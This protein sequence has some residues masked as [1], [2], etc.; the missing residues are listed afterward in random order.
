MC[1]W[2]YRPPVIIPVQRQSPR[3]PIKLDW[4]GFQSILNHDNVGVLNTPNIVGEWC[5]Y[6]SWF[7]RGLVCWS[8][9]NVFECDIQCELNVICF[10]QK[11]LLIF[12]KIWSWIFCEL[13]TICCARVWNNTAH[14]PGIN[15]LADLKINI[16]EASVLSFNFWYL[17]PFF[18]QSCCRRS[19]ILQFN[20]LQV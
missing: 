15:E 12:L 7:F 5:L 11:E 3:H 13:I 14:R 6:H 1:W 4:W 10:G 20:C 16:F 2:Y 18:R 8:F 19:C 17:Q 9:D